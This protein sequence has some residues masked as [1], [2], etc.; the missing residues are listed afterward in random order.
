MFNIGGFS[1]S[2]FVN[3]GAVGFFWLVQLVLQVVLSTWAYRDARQRGNSKEFA[4]IV[5]VGV[6]LVP[7]AGAIVYFLIREDRNDKPIF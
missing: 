5:M 2:Q 4:I 7:L 6:L 1:P 3:A